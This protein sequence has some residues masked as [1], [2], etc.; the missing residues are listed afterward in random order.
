MEAGGV[1]ESW[2]G[3]EEYDVTSCMGRLQLFSVNNNDGDK[4]MFISDFFP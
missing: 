2:Y 4:G 1:F 3:D